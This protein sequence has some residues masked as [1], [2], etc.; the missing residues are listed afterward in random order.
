MFA[1]FRKQLDGITKIGG[2]LPVTVALATDRTNRTDKRKK[3]DLA[4]KKRFFIFQNRFKSVIVGQ[5][6]FF[7]SLA[8]KGAGR[9]AAQTFV[10]ASLKRLVNFTWSISYLA[11]W[12]ILISSVT[13]SCKSL[14]L[15]GGY[16][17]V[18]NR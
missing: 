2:Y 14:P 18:I 17:E 6:N 3:I 15:N 4:A 12:A 7:G 8:L 11:I 10:P 16:K 13:L 1:K 9:Q 5:L